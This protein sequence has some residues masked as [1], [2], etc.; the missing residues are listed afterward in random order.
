[1]RIWGRPWARAVRDAFPERIESLDKVA[2]FR[3]CSFGARETMTFEGP[4]SLATYPRGLPGA[5]QSSP[6]GPRASG[7]STLALQ[8]FASLLR[9]R[10]IY[11]SGDIC[12]LPCFLC[13]VDFLC[14]PLPRQG[15]RCETS[16][17][18][19]LLFGLRETCTF[20]APGGARRC[21]RRLPLFP[22]PRRTATGRSL[23]G[24]RQPPGA[25]FK[26]RGQRRTMI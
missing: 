1:M 22:G 13:C 23:G 21:P 11:D 12:A 14:F 25:I 8:T 3:N 24:S 17:F 7:S 9:A 4:G 18:R 10:P 15:A 16:V 19:N 26:K 5:I 2:V 6:G 20:G